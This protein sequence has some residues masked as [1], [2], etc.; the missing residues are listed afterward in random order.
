MLVKRML[1]DPTQGMSLLLSLNG[2]HV[3]IITV[4]QA[5]YLAL[6]SSRCVTHWAAPW[7]LPRHRFGHRSDQMIA[8][9]LARIQFHLLH[10]RDCRGEI[11]P[12]YRT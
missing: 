9:S 6:A 5:S 10:R 12:I 11:E 1:V 8:W 2:R 7:V 4:R 3:F